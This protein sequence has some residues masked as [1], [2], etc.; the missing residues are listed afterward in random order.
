[1]KYTLEKGREENARDYELKKAVYSGEYYSH[2]NVNEFDYKV[3][4]YEYITSDMFRSA[5]SII[6]DLV[7]I[8]Q[9]EVDFGNGALNEKIQEI[10]DVKSF[11]ARL[12]KFVEN[13]KVYGSSYVQLSQERDDIHI[14]NISPRI[15]YAQYNPENPQAEPEYFYTLIEKEIGSNTYTLKTIYSDESIIYLAYVDY[16]QESQKQVDAKKYF[17]VPEATKVEED[18]LSYSLITDLEYNVFQGVQYNVKDDC[19]YGQGD[20]SMP[21]LSKLNYYNRL[22]NLC[23]VIFTYN[24]FP[25]F[26][27]SEEVMKL[28]NQ[29]K[30]ETNAR[31]TEQLAT[32]STF[33]NE[34]PR[35][36]AFLHSASYAFTSAFKKM[37]DK[38]YIFPAGRAGGDNKYI[39]N[40]YNMNYLF[41]E[42][43][44]IKQ[45]LF[46]EMY[47]SKMFY[48]AQ[49]NTGQMSEVAMRRLMQKTINHV[50]DL[51][52][53]IESPLQKIFYNIA[54][55]KFGYTGSL[56][57]IKW[58]GIVLED[59]KSA[60]E[61]LA[62]VDAIKNRYLKTKAGAMT[63]DVPES[64]VA[65]SLGIDIV[66]EVA[67][68]PRSLEV[69]NNLM[70][71]ISNV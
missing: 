18:G 2:F 55:T 10:R 13:A 19:Y 15:T 33:M 20:L 65:R 8:G 54:N 58:A 32:P 1:M 23:D 52:Y 40:E 47:I 35:V 41:D 24:A 11:Y 56:P 57:K 28:V 26:Q 9:M 48:D 39:I 3:H 6:V 5:V 53:L 36:N 61:N 67:T 30:E 68:A 70:T 12:E 62:K 34:S 51:Q 43:A 29:A 22:I 38:L 66:E 14:Y 27:G 4:S 71:A 17:E 50:E 25:K 49:M 59:T 46:D 60:I 44:T 7:K 16:A 64:E 42:R 31:P 21:I 37:R 63:L 45:E 69:A